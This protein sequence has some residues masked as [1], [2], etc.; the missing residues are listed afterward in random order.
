MENQQKRTFDILAAGE[1][2]IDFISSDFADKLEDVKIF[3]R[4]QGGS[5]AN[6]CLNMARL[7]NS[8]KLIASVGRD[9]MGDYLY[10]CVQNQGVNCDQLRKVKEPT[11]LILVT[12]TKTVANFE[13]YRGADCQ[14]VGE[15][16]PVLRFGEFRIFHTTCFA[17]SKEPA[18]STILR[19]ARLAVQEACQ[20]SL[21]TNYAQKIWPDRRQAQKII[22]KYCSMGAMV[23]VSEVDWERLYENPLQDAETAAQHFLDLGATV[24]C[25]T[26]G[27]EG[28]FVASTSERF[29]LPARKVEIKDTT[30][31]GDAFWSGFLTA[32]LDGH[33]LQN[34]AKAGRRMAE[35]K[36]GHFGNLPLEVGRAEIYA[37]F[38]PDKIY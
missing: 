14:I 1:L 35:I 27:H 33:S 38:L 11:S 22:A 24:V 13:A 23:K 21:D 34:C 25:V 32:W 2:L 12:R 7:G 3:E 29:L 28:C 26:M 17:L 18:L 19:A 36:L 37:D 20:L 30:G 6:L 10:K 15:Q 31:A 16:F 9:D 4:F 5:P 8:V